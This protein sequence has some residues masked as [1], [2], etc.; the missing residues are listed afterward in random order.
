LSQPEFDGIPLSVVAHCQAVPLG[1]LVRG[2]LE[3][4]LDDQVLEQILRDH[5]PE[6][7]TRELTI[8]ALVKLLIQVSA[9]SRASVFAAF[10]ADQDLPK[11]SITTSYQALYGKLGRIQPAVSAALVRH[12]ADRLGLLLHRLPAT[13]DQPIPGYRLRV[14]DGN[15]LAR[16]HHRLKALRPWRNA[17]LPGK[18]L[19]VYEPGLGLATDL[20]LCEDAY[21]AERALLVQLL[22]RVQAADLWLADRNFCTTRFVFGIMGRQGF[23]LIRQHRRALPCRP[24]DRLRRCGETATGIVY[25]QRVQVTDPET[26]EQQVLRRIEVRLFEKTRDG[27]RTI[28]LLTNLPDTVT[29]VDLAETYRQRWTIE[30][31]FQFLTESLHCEVKGLGKPRA[32]LL[33]FAMALVAGNALA[34]VRGTLRSAHGQEAEAEISG[35]YLADE[36]GADYRTL[37]KYLPAD[38][39]TGW[40]SLRAPDMANLLITIAAHVRLGALR[41]NR[42]G[43][44]KPP[45]VKPVYNKKH[46]HYSTARLLKEETENS[47]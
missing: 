38:Q 31:H 25:E 22:P 45:V 32:A 6:Q 33:L 39:W 21:T 41:R 7:Y 3:W 27:E 11:P 35:Y 5:A 17:C 23:F 2:I 43:P 34:V 26:G 10:Q 36:I 1:L 9:G 42:R 29:A 14:L 40:R 18:S 12:S 44:K 47:C 28:A 16:T 24:I 20:V 19:V 15:V 46:K 8:S 30:K 37:M 13:A 4:L